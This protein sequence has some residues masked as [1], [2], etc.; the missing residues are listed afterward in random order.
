MKAAVFTAIRK[1][2][3][4]DMPAPACPPGWARIKVL[5]AGVCSTDVHI[6][7]GTFQHA[8]PPAILGH[9][10]A[11]VV[12]AVGESV[13]AFRV[14]DRV[15]V[16]TAVGCGLCMYCR[17][18][19]KHLCDEGGEIGFPP[20]QG[21][22]A[23]YTIAPQTCLRRVPN[24]ISFD[25][26]GILEA[27][28]CPFGAVER[29]GMRAGEDV[30][31]IGGGIAALAFL[32]SVTRHS[33]RRVILATRR[34]ENLK[35]AYDMGAT[36]VIGLT[37]WVEYVREITHGGATLTIDAA[38]APGTGE[39]AVACTRKQGRIVLYGIPKDPISLSVED[40]VLRQLS[41]YGVTNN[42]LTW[43]TLLTQ[44]ESGAMRI[45]PFVTHVFALKEIAQA[46]DL[47][48][49]RPAGLIKAVIHPWEE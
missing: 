19:N 15:T 49:K 18:G 31:I 37:D 35:I 29:L 41:I 25:E 30:V 5:S 23:Q 1:L 48:Q 34:P 2:E 4:R 8:Q 13:Q 40:I 21:G 33:P 39:C 17:T 45:A 28:A 9:E 12:D 26:A 14:G 38:G 44:V 36:Q 20:Y 42:E 46:F 7:N 27:V 24:T 16:E 32:Q 43:D 6:V 47:V 3:I 11:G 10:I 22:Y